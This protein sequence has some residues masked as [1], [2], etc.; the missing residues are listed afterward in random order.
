MGLAGRRASF[1]LGGAS[2]YQRIFRDGVNRGTP[3]RYL[4]R[5]TAGRLGGDGADWAGDEH[6]RLLGGD[7]GEGGAA[8]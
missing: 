4:Q 8:P 3:G 1:L 6:V 2:S 7:A 5:N